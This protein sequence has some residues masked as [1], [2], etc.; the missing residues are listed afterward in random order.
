[1]I[2]ILFSH[3]RHALLLTGITLLL[4]W[5]SPTYAQEQQRLTRIA[6]IKIDSTQLEPYKI[7]LK[8][9]IETALQ[10]EPGVLV[11]YAVYDKNQPT[12]V[13]VFEVYAN[14]Q[15]YQAH[16]QTP[17]FKKYKNETASMVQSLE[18]IDVVPIVSINTKKR[19]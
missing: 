9:G 7:L 3:V 5:N 14:N 8:E 18:L 10:V 11:L 2:N 15:A 1:M 6:R 16:L 17:H 19:K 4:L 12:N 13:T